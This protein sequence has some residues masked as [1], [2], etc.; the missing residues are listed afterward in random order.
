M[1]SVPATARFAVL[2]AVFAF[3]LGACG[4]D[5][6]ELT[7]LHPPVPEPV[8]LAVSPGESSVGDIRIFNFEAETD[9]GDPV[10]FD[11]IMTT[12]AIDA[13]EPGLETRSSTASLSFGSHNDQLIVEGIALYPG[14]GSVLAVGDTSQRAIVGGSGRFAGA[15]G[16]IV[17]TQL[18][19]G[20]WRH[21]IILD[22]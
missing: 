9:S 4:S 22:D 10:T 15:N 16:E 20:S 11:W 5:T 8:L 7:V 14:A 21:E 17:S 19:D 2:V 13:P 3:V 12:T 6:T 1:S 18:D